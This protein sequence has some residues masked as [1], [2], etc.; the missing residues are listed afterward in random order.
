MTVYS[1][2]TDLYTYLWV[3]P[4]SYRFFFFWLCVCFTVLDGI[5]EDGWDYG[6]QCELLNNSKKKNLMKRGKKLNLF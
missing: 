4:M 1:N 5:M 6:S 2:E 3:E